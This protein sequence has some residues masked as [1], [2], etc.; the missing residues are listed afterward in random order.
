MRNFYLTVNGKRYSVSVE[1]DP[2][3][4]DIHITIDGQTHRVRIEEVSLPTAPHPTSARRQTPESA[5]DGGKI[6]APLPGVVLSVN[7]A[8]GDA[9]R[10]GDTLL[11]LE[12]MK[13]E[14]VI[15]AD[16]D[17]VVQALHVRKGDKVE[18]AQ[19]LLEIS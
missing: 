14:N 3:S 13:M 5:S 10:A 16:S 1:R 19:L 12:A 8:P 4:Q 18:A 7:V 17:C 11:V 6:L 9:A 15:T 2:G